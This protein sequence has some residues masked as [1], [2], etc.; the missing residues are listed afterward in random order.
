MR[1]IL[2]IPELPIRRVRARRVPAVLAIVAALGLAAGPP[3]SAEEPA[4]APG[5]GLERLLKL[6]DTLD[7]GVERRGGATRS[8]WRARFAEAVAR[9]EQA[10]VALQAAQDE[11]A[12]LGGESDAWTV[13]PPGV[14][15]ASSDAPLSFQLR[16]EIKRQEA[17]VARSKARLSDLQV[18]ANLAGVPNHWRTPSTESQ[19]AD[20][21]VVT[22]GETP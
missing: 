16:Q 5:V 1:P 22:P 21:S 20:D 4:K 9:Q 6:P 12:E 18:E 14:G 15:A 3:A 19:L 13:G 8:E 10:E 17:E 7:Y 2:S 11:L